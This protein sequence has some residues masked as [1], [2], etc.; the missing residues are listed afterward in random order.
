MGIC[1]FF[2]KFYA[3]DIK[4][5]LIYCSWMSRNMKLSNKKKYFILFYFILFILFYF[6]LFHFILLYLY[7][8]LA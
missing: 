3:S 1:L 5:K 6:I 8:T 7:M 2:N 4:P